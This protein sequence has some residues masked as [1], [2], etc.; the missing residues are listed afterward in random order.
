MIAAFRRT[1]VLLVLGLV[2]HHS[3]AGADPLAPVAQATPAACVALAMP[4]LRGAD[5]SGRETAAGL[6]DLVA[7]FLTGPSLR[8]EP[9]E[10]R[11]ASQAAEEARNKGCPSVLSLTLTRKRSGGGGLGRVLGSAADAAAWRLPYGGSARSNVARGAAIAGAAAAAD[12]AE[13]TKARDEWELEYRLTV[14][15]RADQSGKDAGKAKADGEDV[16]TP[17][18]EHLANVVAAAVTRK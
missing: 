2:V 3:P 17:L 16:V 10:A 1:A 9:L 12:I 11:L 15:G 7:S 5:G 8:T 18:V 14:D 13:N 4:T 6:R